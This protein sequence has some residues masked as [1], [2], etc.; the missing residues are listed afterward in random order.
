MLQTNTKLIFTEGGMVQEL[1]TR[2]QQLRRLQNREVLTTQC[3]KQIDLCDVISV[4]G[5][6]WGI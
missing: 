6:G 2:V 1:Y 4:N 3:G 5:I